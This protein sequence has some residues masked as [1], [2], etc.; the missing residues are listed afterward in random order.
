MSARIASGLITYS[1]MISIHFG[2]LGR[3]WD[4]LTRTR[5]LRVASRLSTR[6]TNV[7]KVKRARITGDRL[8]LYTESWKMVRP[9]TMQ[10]KES[11]EFDNRASVDDYT[12]CCVHNVVEVVPDDSTINVIGVS[13]AG[14]VHN[15]LG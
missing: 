9:L 10:S 14:E 13:T 2:I 12:V 3:T 6:G 4:I 1:Q 11:S 15:A 5:R 7:T 8:D